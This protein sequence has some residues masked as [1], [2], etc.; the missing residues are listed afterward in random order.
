[1]KRNIEIRRVKLQP[2]YCSSFKQRL[3]IVPSLYVSGKWLSIA[4]F[5]PQETVTITV[6]KDCLIIRK[7]NSGQEN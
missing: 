2:K 4:G 1:M 7:D 6:K 5:Q 3:F